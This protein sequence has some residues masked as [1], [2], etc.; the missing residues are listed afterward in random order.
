MLEGMTHWFMPWYFYG[1]LCENVTQM[2]KL[3][4]KQEISGDLRKKRESQLNS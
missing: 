4:K 3:S 1:W 2:L